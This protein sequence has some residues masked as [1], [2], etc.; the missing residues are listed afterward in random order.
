MLYNFQ[1]LG[2]IQASVL[3]YDNLIKITED[4]KVIDPKVSGWIPADGRSIDGSLLHLRTGMKNA[5]DLRGKFLRGLNTIYNIG[6]P[7][8]DENKADPQPNRRPGDY[9]EDALRTHT[10]SY[11]DRQ[12]G[13]G[14]Q[15]DGGNDVGLDKVETKNTNATGDKETRPKNVSVYFYIK[16]N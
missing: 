1:L 5:P 6:E 13:V 14:N 2:T 16:I 15:A 9:Q 8:L 11:T 4:P 12:E 7:V 10:H 3:D